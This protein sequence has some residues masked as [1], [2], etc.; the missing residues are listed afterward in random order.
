MKYI[1]SYEEFERLNKALHSDGAF[2]VVKDKKGKV[3]V[4]TIGWAMIGVVWGK[5]MMT[6]FVRPARYTHELIENAVSFSVC[7]PNTGKM[8]EELAF[9]GT[10]SG[11]MVDKI[12]QCGLSL[13]QGKH[14]D[15]VLIDDCKL[16]YECEIVEKTKML[17]E[18]L[19]HEITEEFY[20]KK[21]FHSIYFGEIKHCYI[22][23]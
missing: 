19:S 8:K 6:V 20:P 18:T 12:K 17:P 11:K 4:M 5:P 22:R 16:F 2:L 9:C 14:K 10:S 3:N 7:V 23:E 13:V 21:D 1:K 15:N